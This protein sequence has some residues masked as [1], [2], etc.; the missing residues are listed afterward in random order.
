MKARQTIVVLVLCVLV[1]AGIAGFVLTRDSGSGGVRAKSLRPQLVDEQPIQTARRMAALASTREEQR[2][3]QHA[4]RLA[5][6]A[7]DL[8]FA[9]AMREATLHQGGSTREEKELF[10]RVGRAEAQVKLDQDIIDSLKKETSKATPASGQE[11]Q[12]QLDMVQAQMELDKDD[13]DNAQADLLRSGADPLSRIQ[14]Q[15]ARYQAQQ[16]NE[17]ARAQSAMPSAEAP[18]PPSHFIGQ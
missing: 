10:A 9:G 5:D 7:V 13:L 14:R 1:G 6:H 2:F 15:F 16:Q 18:A 11:I 17:A 8:A 4:V 12:K 3:A